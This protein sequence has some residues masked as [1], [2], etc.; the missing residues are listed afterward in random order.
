MTYNFK[1]HVVYS[2]PQRSW[3]NKTTLADL[4]IL[5]SNYTMFVIVIDVFLVQIPSISVKSGKSFTESTE[6]DYIQQTCDYLGH[7]TPNSYIQG[8]IQPQMF[9]K[10][11]VDDKNKV[12]YHI[13]MLSTYLF[14]I[15][16]TLR[17]AKSTAFFA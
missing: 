3:I 1:I 2:M 14:K 17:F 12:I 15:N 7:H 4:W 10:F 5:S 6:V 16:R 11:L 13:H 8:Q 9:R